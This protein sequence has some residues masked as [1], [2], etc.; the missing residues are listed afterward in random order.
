MELC[1]H[2][3]NSS[4]LVVD[5]NIL[6][7]YDSV[8]K[9]ICLDYLAIIQFP[10]T[11][12]VPHTLSP[13]R[14]GVKKCPPGIDVA[15]EDDYTGVEDHFLGGSLSST[16]LPLLRRPTM[17]TGS[18]WVPRDLLIFIFFPLINPHVADRK[19]PKV[20]IYCS[21]CSLRYTRILHSETIQVQHHHHHHHVDHHH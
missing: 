2:C 11:T 7:V 6:S 20:S 21:P 4:D 16:W 3:K 13:A 8:M 14:G 10:G 17:N 19:Y 9:Q 12:M 15:H 18:R 5:D 1:S